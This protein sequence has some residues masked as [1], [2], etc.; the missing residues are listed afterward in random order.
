MRHARGRRVL[1]WTVAAS[2]IAATGGCGKPNFDPATASA[3]AV[4]ADLPAPSVADIYGE[5]RETRIGP[6]DKLTIEVLG[7]EDLK[8][9]V[10]VDG[11]GGVSYPLVGRVEALGQTPA[12]L[13]QALQGRLAAKYLQDPQVTVTVAD[14]VSQRFTI[15]GGVTRPGIYPVV[16]DATLSDAVAL[17]SGT[18]EFARLRE[19]V[20][21]RTV[22]GQRMAGR[23]DLREITGGRA[24]D[25]AVFP[26]DRIVVGSDAS[27]SLLRDIV[28]LTPIVGIFYQ[29]L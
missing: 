11:A 12:E 27:R 2:A 16:G 15:L 21:F 24:A 23:F 20:V 6:G 14:S 18:N 5:T 28:Q 13:A 3:V 17:A 10:V 7:V 8:R 9:T 22:N 29:I 26:G 1:I 19:V 4:A 25:P